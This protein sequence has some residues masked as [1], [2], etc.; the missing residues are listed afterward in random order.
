MPVPEPPGDFN[1]W[2]E[3]RAISGWPTSDE[4]SA[5][6]LADAW[7]ATS[8]RFTQAGTHDI[9]DLAE[10]WPDPAGLAYQARVGETL[11]GA[12]TAGT[13]MIELA[14]RAEAF[15]AEVTG[16][17]QG[18]NDLMA[19]NI[20]VYGREV[21][22]LPDVTRPV[23]HAGFVQQLAGMVTEMVT[24]AAA[25]IGTAADAAQG[26]APA[27]SGPPPG[28]TPEQ[29]RDWWESQSLPQRYAIVNDQPDLIRNLDGIPAGFRDMA[30]RAVLDRELAT[31]RGQEADL[32]DDVVAPGLETERHDR[33]LAQIRSK[34]QGLEEIGDRRDS[35]TDLYLLGLDTSL[36]GKAIIASGNPDTAGNIVTH[37]PGVG[38]DL[39][40]VT[41]PG[42]LDRAESLRLRP[43]GTE[44]D[45]NTAAVYW[46]GYDAPDDLEAADSEDFARDGQADLARFQDGLRALNPGAHLTAEGHSYGTTVIGHAARDTG[47]GADGFA[48]DDLVLVGSTDP[49]VQHVSEYH[50]DRVAPADIGE[51]VHVTTA[52]NDFVAQAGTARN[53]ND[54]TDSSFGADVFY[55]RPNYLDLVEL[56]S[57]AASLSPHSNA[58]NEGNPALDRIREITETG[59]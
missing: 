15:A 24:S 5:R 37:V 25:R 29:V 39:S 3:V 7:R 56:G 1:L 14:R 55:T 16:V 44:P 53:G 21:A 27:Q 41:D 43:G 45:P 48:A 18:I 38:H 28:A 26:T 50:L 36:D 30:N 54:P 6:A 58:Y 40:T 20:E 33:Q 46:L 49:G 10:G 12:T 11:R 57:D 17:K 23:A 42:S 59:R 8:E 13:E 22:S 52:A 51:N 2:P 19:A 4:D 31:L 9:G 34:I 32:A 35:G 47:V